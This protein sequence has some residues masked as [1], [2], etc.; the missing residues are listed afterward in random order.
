MYKN[1]IS[2]SQ[3]FICMFL[4]NIF[5]T[6]GFWGQN[7]GANSVATNLFITAIGS[8]LLI[9]VCIPSYLVKKKVGESP[10]SVLNCVNNKFSIIIKTLYLLSYFIFACAFLSKYVKFFKYQINREA[11]E[12]IIILAIVLLCAFG[13]YK[14]V[15]ALFRTNTILFVFF[16]ITLVFIF[17]GLIDKIDF[18]NI[19]LSI[20]HI[21][22]QLSQG[23]STILLTIL[24][25]TTYVVFSD[26]LKG[27]Q[28][29]GI[30]NNAL[31]INALYFIITVCT[32]FVLGEFTNVLKYPTFI[33]SKEANLSVIKGGDGMMFALITTV[34]FILIYLFFISGSLV[35]DAKKSKL[36]PICYALALL[37]A[38][39]V[40]VYIPT[41]YN[42]ITNTL[43][44]S[45][46]AIFLL[47]VIPTFSYVIIKNNR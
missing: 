22:K 31:S 38:T 32:L 29:S 6:F 45:I 25:L 11:V 33:L 19:S 40:T 4:C 42:F 37:V 7:T 17:I 9:L 47:V 44:L 43:F 35:I 1:K 3:F 28:K 20:M 41:V 2:V 5:I 12:F 39:S 15:S 27:N 23:I 13:C 30:I 26:F 18:K 10:I 14:G 34:I 46:L 36:Y 24:P 8:I 16:V 21:N